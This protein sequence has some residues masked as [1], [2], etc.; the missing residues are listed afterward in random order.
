MLCIKDAHSSLEYCLETQRHQNRQKPPTLRNQ[1]S[2]KHQKVITAATP[3]QEF[4]VLIPFQVQSNC[5]CKEAEFLCPYT[6][7]I[8]NNKSTLDMVSSAQKVVPSGT[9]ASH[10]NEPVLC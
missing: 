5:N 6:I 2:S 9:L 3:I 7:N 4:L 1:Q 8:T 10:V